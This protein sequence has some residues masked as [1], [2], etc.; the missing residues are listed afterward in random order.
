ML[1]NLPSTQKAVS[2]VVVVAG[3]VGW[4]FAFV[5][6]EEIDGLKSELVD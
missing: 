3:V 4:I 6:I 5:Q 2:G 1:E